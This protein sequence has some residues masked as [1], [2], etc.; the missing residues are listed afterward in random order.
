MLVTEQFPEV[1]S[2]S[3]FSPCGSWGSA[4]GHEPCS[5][6]HLAS[7]LLAFVVQG[8]SKGKSLCLWVE[9]VKDHVRGMI[10]GAGLWPTGLVQSFLHESDFAETKRS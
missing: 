5:L 10:V 6:S 8:V 9:Q 3:L 2:L 1:T 7:L 4:A